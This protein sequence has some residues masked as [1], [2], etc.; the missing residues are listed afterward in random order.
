MRLPAA[1]RYHR[2]GQHRKAAGITRVWDRWTVKG[3]CGDGEVPNLN[4]RQGGTYI[5]GAE[6]IGL[7]AAD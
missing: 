2:E 5:G 6:K 1:L 7:C 3:L 4:R